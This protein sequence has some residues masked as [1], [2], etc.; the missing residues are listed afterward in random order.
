MKGSLPFLYDTK[1]CTIQFNANACTITMI[2]IVQ[3]EN[4][5]H[6]H[7]HLNYHNS[8]CA[9]KQMVLLDETIDYIFL[10]QVSVSLQ[11]VAYKHNHTLNK[12]AIIQNSNVQ[13]LTSSF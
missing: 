8:F 9:S 11:L 2:C 4:F 3:I 13:C 7:V 12:S 10:S 5:I 6:V 1:I